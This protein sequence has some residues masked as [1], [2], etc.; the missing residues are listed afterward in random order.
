VKKRHSSLPDDLPALDL[1]NSSGEVVDVKRKADEKN[2]SD[3]QDNDDEYL[4][5]KEFGAL[6]SHLSTK[7]SCFVALDIDETIFQTPGAPSYLVTKDG[8]SQFQRFVRERFADYDTRN[9]WCRK[10]GQVLKTKVPVESS[11]VDV[12]KEF[13]E[14]KCWVFGITA[15]FSEMASMTE[16][17]LANLGVNL[18]S[19]APF[20]P[21]RIQD[22]AT[23]ALCANGIIYCNS[24][25][26]GVVLNRFLENVVFR[27][28]LQKPPEHRDKSFLP[29][30]FVFVDDQFDHVKSV[31]HISC[32]ETLG[33]PVSCYHYL[34][35]PSED[36]H[37]SAEDQSQILDLQMRRFV[38]TE[39]VLT[40][41]EA[42]AQLQERSLDCEKALD[43]RGPCLSGLALAK[44]LEAK[45][46]RSEPGPE[47]PSIP[48]KR[49]LPF[50]FMLVTTGA[51]GSKQAVNSV[52]IEDSVSD[53][54]EPMA[55]PSKP[56]P[57]LQILIPPKVGRKLPAGFMLVTTGEPT[58]PESP[59]VEMHE[60]K[61][62]PAS[63]NVVMRE[64]KSEP[65]SPNVV[66]DEAKSEQ[67]SEVDS[68]SPTLSSEEGIRQSPYFAALEAER[69]KTDVVPSLAKKD[70][71]PSIRQKEKFLKQK[72][73]KK[74]QKAKVGFRRSDLRTF[75]H[76]H[77]QRQQQRRHRKR[78][79]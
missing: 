24:L 76:V 2:I 6:R 65:A 78:G 32:L 9:M 42:K 40:N 10:L 35:H 20:P 49:N 5:L 7:P 14:Q 1:S 52:S 53:K 73:N 69:S 63:P 71:R 79:K 38:E 15:R 3:A 8:V 26:K 74:V 11:T 77:G 75:V 37:V 59:N 33:I 34:P 28:F 29:S 18:A 36:K 41:E 70:E 25:D 64:A 55:T 66:M 23:K 54:S 67:L 62:E 31:R 12:I 27:S 22:P 21:T 45:A 56:L 13:Q 48:L 30:S 44:P 61:S 19:T 60:A 4:Q 47:P 16:K 58:P 50:P 39:R 51:P 57:K 68:L 43:E 72:M 46:D 17:Q